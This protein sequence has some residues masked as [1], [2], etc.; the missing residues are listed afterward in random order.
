MW[1]ELVGFDCIIYKPQCAE[2]SRE[3]CGKKPSDHSE[4]EQPSRLWNDLIFRSWPLP[5][6]S[7][8]GDADGR[9]CLC[10][11]WVWCLT[12]QWQLSQGSVCYKPT[13][14]N[15]VT[16]LPFFFFFPRA[17]SAST[18]GSAT[19]KNMRNNTAFVPC[20]ALGLLLNKCSEEFWCW[21]CPWARADPTVTS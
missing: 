1:E 19:S 8:L 21:P 18:S 10:V 14:F 13:A 15:P 16:L 4:M 11:K 5:F 20:F 12:L 7:A 2:A 6:Q 3:E 17:L 9:K